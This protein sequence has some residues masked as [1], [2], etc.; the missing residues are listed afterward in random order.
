MSSDLATLTGAYVVNALPDDERAEFEVHLADCADCRQEVRE[1]R[2]AAARLGAAEHTTAPEELKQRVLAEI[3]QTRQDP[4]PPAE[5]R[6]LRPRTRASWG[7]RLSVAAAALGVALAA[8]FGVVAVQAQQEL[9]ATRE[10]MIAAGARGAEISAMLQAPDAR[11]VNAAG[12]EGMRATTVLSAEQGKAM[13]MATGMTPAPDDRVYQLW[14][15]DPSGTATSAGLLNAART[16]HT[17]PL[18]A[19]MPATTAQLGLTIEPH[20]GSPAPTTTPI[21]T[22]P[23]T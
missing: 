22:L 21:L 15:I 20:G 23:T 5:V 1:L 4:P 2:E 13:F 3:S 14:F 17:E 8:A 19:A 11:V 6:T 12:P 10:R 9:D 7:T 18:I 16:E